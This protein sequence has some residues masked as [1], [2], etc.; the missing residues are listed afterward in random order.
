[1][2]AFLPNFD[3]LEVVKMGVAEELDRQGYDFVA[4]L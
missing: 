3:W 1:L 4:M 2:L